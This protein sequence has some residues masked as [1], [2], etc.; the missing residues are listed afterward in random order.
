VAVKDGI[1]TR[2]G[3]VASDALGVAGVKAAVVI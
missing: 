3:Y 1:V 2:T